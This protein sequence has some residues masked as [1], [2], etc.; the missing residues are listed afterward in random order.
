MKKLLFFLLFMPLISISQSD[1]WK[2]NMSLISTENGVK[3]ALSKNWM[4]AINEYNSAI[5]LDPEN[6]TAYYNRGVAKYNLEDYRGA[7]SD[8]Q[9]AIGCKGI[10]TKT[11]ADTYYMAG[12]SAYILGYIDSA[13]KCF[14][15]GGELG[16]Q[17]CYEIIKEKC[18]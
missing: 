17:E 16:N 3:Y 9:K 13:C 7:Y 1:D 4:K 8:C 14:S 6:Y 18:K 2:K 12:L 11:K 10:D 5:V 15:W